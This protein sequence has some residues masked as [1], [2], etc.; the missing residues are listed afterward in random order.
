[1]DTPQSYG[2]DT[3]TTEQQTCR[4]DV[5]PDRSAPSAGKRWDKPVPGL[6]LPGLWL[7]TAVG[8]LV[9]PFLTQYRVLTQLSGESVQR[10][11]ADEVQNDYRV[12]GWG[13]VDGLNDFGT[14]HESPVGILF[15]AVAALLILA[16]VATIRSRRGTWPMWVGLLASS[17]A[18]T[19]SVLQLVE[20]EARLLAEDTSGSMRS[21]V[22]V[23]PVAWL[24]VAV[25]L[26]A[27][28]AIALSLVRLRQRQRWM[29]QRPI[30]QP[31]ID[32]PPFK[33]MGLCLLATVLL[34]VAPFLTFIQLADAANADHVL[35]V[36][37]W[38]RSFRSV[39]VPCTVLALGLGV[40]AITMAVRRAAVWPFRLGLLTGAG[41]VTLAGFQ[42]IDLIGLTTTRASADSEVTLSI[43]LGAWLVLAAGVLAAVT[44]ALTLVRQWRLS[45]T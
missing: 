18:V 39:G 33:L 40:T 31:A 43:G 23:G 37:G 29:P 8:L 27:V 4:E 41:A 42:L 38:H 5:G 30:P 45:V 21:D 9:V 3:P 12:N 17:M 19:A 7:A 13:Q 15:A 36:D 28:V 2:T 14:V 16:V 35:Q 1:M 20:L 11:I 34:V 32:R 24:V 44:V 10:G 26:L 25:G 22:T 6:Q